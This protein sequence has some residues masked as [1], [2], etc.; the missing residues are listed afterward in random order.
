MSELPDGLPNTC[1]DCDD[2]EYHTEH[3]DENG[4]RVIKVT[5]QRGSQKRIRR[6]TIGQLLRPIF[7]E[8][9][10]ELE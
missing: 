4:I 6:V 5:V 1:L 9:T 2:V 10:E 8:L 3:F 7:D